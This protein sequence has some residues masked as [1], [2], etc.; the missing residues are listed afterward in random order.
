ML[1][2]NPIVKILVSYLASQIF[3]CES[4]LGRPHKQTNCFPK[5][6]NVSP[7]ITVK[8]VTGGGTFVTRDIK[9]SC[10]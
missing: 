8:Y 3:E 6:T 1:T 2:F 9:R 4:K 10:N 5:G 7:F